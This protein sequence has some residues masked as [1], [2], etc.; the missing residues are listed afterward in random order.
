MFSDGFLRIFVLKKA[1]KYTK[2][3]TLAKK[4]ILRLDVFFFAK[5][6]NL[7]DAEI[8]KYE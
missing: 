6:N 7:F 3:L 2:C 5:R 8:H 1:F 4:Q